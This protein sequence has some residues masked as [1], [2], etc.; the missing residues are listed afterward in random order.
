MHLHL[1]AQRIAAVLVGASAYAAI[2]CLLQGNQQILAWP[3]GTWIC[4]V[5]WPT[6]KTVLR[7]QRT[8][9]GFSRIALRWSMPA[10]SIATL[11]VSAFLLSRAVSARPETSSDAVLLE[12]TRIDDLVK[13]GRL[14]EAMLA[15]EKL[16][17]PAGMP[18]EVARKHHNAA[19]VLIQMR[20]PEL[21]VEHLLLSLKHDPTNAQAA[22]L[23]A[24]LAADKG[25]VEEAKAMLD[26][27][28]AIQPG[29]EPAKRLRQKLAG[30]PSGAG[31]SRE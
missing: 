12:L 1:A 28:L 14:P 13:E 3:V 11:C 20:R 31:N 26:I 17:V 16:N 10:I 5:A 7:R 22:Y 23:L 8:S 25:R 19:V 2:L 4:L 30:R 21:A 15:L 18:R 9:N 27:A 29:Y 6:P 24:V